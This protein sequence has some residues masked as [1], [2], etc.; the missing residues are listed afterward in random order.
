MSLV[1]S[2]DVATSKSK[3]NFSVIHKNFS[4]TIYLYAANDPVIEA[5]S[6]LKF[7][8]FNIGYPHLRQHA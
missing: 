7:A 4:S 1:S 8:P 2:L 6:G 3:T 5:S